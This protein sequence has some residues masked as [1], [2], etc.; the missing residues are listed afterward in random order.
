MCTLQLNEFVSES[1][2]HFTKTGVVNQRM[3]A[4]YET[5]L[6]VISQS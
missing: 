3:E 1:I 2:T 6:D 4:T 5:L